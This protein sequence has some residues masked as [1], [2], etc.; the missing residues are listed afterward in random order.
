[1]TGDDAHQPPPPDRADEAYWRAFLENPDSLMGVGRRLFSR[2]P[3]DPRCQLC[4]SPFA[5]VGGAMMRAIGKKQSGVN[6]TICTSCEKQLLN[7]RGGAEVETSMLF[8]DIRGS[9]ALGERLSPSDFRETLN[10]YYS[11]A[12]DVV[13]EHG[14]IV[15]KFV[16]DELVAAFPP[17]LGADHA[18][19]AVDAATELLRRTGHA[20]PDG[21]WVPVGAGV[22]TGRLWFGTV[23][24]GS[25][26]EITVLGDVVNTTARLAS[27]AE[28]GEVLV[29]LDAARAAGLDDSPRTSQS[30]AERQGGSDRGGQR[31]H[32]Y[33]T[34]M[35]FAVG[36]DAY[37][38]FMGRYSRGLSAPFAD[39]AGIVAGQRALDVGCGPGI[40][41]EELVARLGAD[42]VA[43]VDPSSSFVEAARAR[44]PG[45][46]VA[47][48]SAEALPFPDEAFD[49]TLAQLVVHFMPDPVAGLRE[50]RRVTRPGGV[51]AAS[52]W[53][54][55][56]GQ[57]PLGVFW[58]AAHE[59][60]EE[61]VD[62][63]GMPARGRAISPSCSRRPGWATSRRRS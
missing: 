37:E 10:R 17:F 21:P 41:T 14:G 43:A 25:H 20:G 42:A 2:L 53:D 63:S 54:H 8:A 32:R 60:G 19:R 56:G 51:V 35:T 59:I 46:T 36:A 3:A 39:F 5:G 49:A 57:G 34:A 52:V 12:S 7:R 26:V 1:M 48:A 45:V 22:N 30:R 9:T 61:V 4:A 33:A 47:E 31:P 55:A 29:S 24:E 62:E 58:R 16:G 40:L 50:M 44:L 27:A 18:R 13:Y 15:D 23:G 38:A 28:S 6:P 11:V